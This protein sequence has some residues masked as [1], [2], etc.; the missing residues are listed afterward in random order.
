MKTEVWHTH[1]DFVARGVG[2]DTGM[3]PDHEGDDPPT[4]VA[5]HSP[6]LM[7]AAVSIRAS[8]QPASSFSMS[9]FGITEDPD[10]ESRRQRG[11]IFGV[12]VAVGLA[13][14][15]VVIGRS[16]SEPAPKPKEEK[17][18]AAAVAPPPP[19]PVTSL[20]APAAS[21]KPKEEAKPAA[22]EKTPEKPAPKH[23]RRR[24][25]SKVAD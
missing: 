23:H 8:E 21:D 22:S 16:P 25:K 14:A 20:P 4:T 1:M 2:R 24:T 5:D 15:A 13:I 9:S 10:G 18:V 12:V 19:A 3:F 17:P 7:P 11:K 6:S